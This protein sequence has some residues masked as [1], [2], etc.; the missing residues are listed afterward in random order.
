MEFHFSIYCGQLAF[1]VLAGDVLILSLRQWIKAASRRGTHK[2]IICTATSP[3][4]RAF[5]VL[6][7]KIIIIIIL[8]VVTRWRG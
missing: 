7:P 5:A 6:E 4:S 1:G 2:N 3:T 8:A